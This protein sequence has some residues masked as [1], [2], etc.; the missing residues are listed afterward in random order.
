MLIGD[1]PLIY[2][3]HILVAASALLI[4]LPVYSD[5]DWSEFK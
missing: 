4:R 5:S 2:Q 3:D 1:E